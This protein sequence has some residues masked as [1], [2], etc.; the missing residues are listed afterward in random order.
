MDQVLVNHFYMNFTDKVVLITGGSRGIGKAASIAFAKN[1]AQ[2]VFN[3]KSNTQAANDTIRQ[4]LGKSHL[5]IKADI[6][7]PQT[8]Q[9]LVNAVIKQKGKIDILVNNAG[10]FMPHKIDEVNY[11]DWQNAWQQTMQTNLFAAANLCYC[12]GQHMI[13]QKSG[14]I[15][16]VSSRG[17]FRGEP[18]FP[19]YGASK[20]AM[21]AMSQSLAKA[22]GKYN[23]SV[24]AIAPGFVET[25]MAKAFLEGP[26]GEVIKMQSPMNRVATPEEVAHAIL[27]YASDEAE[28]MTGGIMDVNGASYFR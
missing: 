20:A 15:I 23:I 21:N 13:K 12:V 5:A 22:L 27:F 26:E 3:F 10:I 25:D 18:D 16:N 2:V 14:R 7:N 11:H 8:V 24:T 1:G 9:K 19:A 28:F 17:A 6:G 4:L